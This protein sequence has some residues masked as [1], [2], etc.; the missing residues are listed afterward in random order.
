MKRV[1]CFGTFDHLHPG[2]EDFL[3]QARG[4]GDHL[5]VIVARDRTVEHVKGHRPLQLEGD[6]LAAIKTARYVDE[7][8]LGSMGKDK[9]AVIEEVKPDVIVLGY[10]QEAFTDGLAQELEERGF[11][12]LI[13]RAH[14]FHPERYKSSLLKE[15]S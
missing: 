9:Y 3:R 11:S 2:H 1:L 6:R 13:L 15:E 7:A 12:C 8:Y 5:T 10:D 4:Q 14:A